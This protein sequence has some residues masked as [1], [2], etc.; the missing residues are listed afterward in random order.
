MFT[1]QYLQRGK[2]NPVD[3]RKII[4]EHLP[5]VLAGCA[6]YTASSRL[7]QIIAVYVFICAF[8]VIPKLTNPRH[9]TRFLIEMLLEIIGRDLSDGTALKCN[10]YSIYEREQA[11]GIVE[12]VIKFVNV[13]YM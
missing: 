8:H 3:Y 7:S 12:A 5:F 10:K 6:K 4:A 9:Q 1:K 11:E 2:I 13:K